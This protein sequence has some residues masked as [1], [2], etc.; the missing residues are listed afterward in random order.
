ML[1]GGT[2]LAGGFPIRVLRLTPS[3][4]GHVA[5]WWSGTPVPDGPKAR[6]LDAD[7]GQAPGSAISRTWWPVALPVA[8]AVRRLR[9]PLDWLDRRPP[10]DP[11][12]YV[13]ARLLDDIA[14]SLGVW[15]G[16][17]ELRTA[18]PL[19]PLVATGK[20]PRLPLPLPRR[21]RGRHLDIP[22]VGDSSRG[23]GGG[24]TGSPRTSAGGCPP[25]MLA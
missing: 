7:G 16:C 24:G 11:G 25:A 21:P 10:L 23:A 9:L 19:L 12:R 14:Y 15:Q 3:G 8:V 1:A 2:V 4:A 13:I 20:P 22:G 18:R 6:A 5:G 17:A